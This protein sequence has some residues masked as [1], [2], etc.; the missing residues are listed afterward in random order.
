MQ[1]QTAISL[2]PDQSQILLE[3]Y[4]KNRQNFIKLK[5]RPS[6]Y[7]SDGLPWLRASSAS[8]QNKAAGHATTIGRHI[9]T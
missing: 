1:G 5:V 2:S 7:V 4:D 8:Y 3:G 6:V 9:H